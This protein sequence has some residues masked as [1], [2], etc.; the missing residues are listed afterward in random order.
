MRTSSR[1]R[2]EELAVV[3]RRSVRPSPSG[4]SGQYRRIV[5]FGSPS[6]PAQSQSRGRRPGAASLALACPP[7]GGSRRLDDR[8]PVRDA[9][10]PVQRLIANDVAV[11]DSQVSR[12]L[13]RLRRA[14]PPGGARATT[15]S[16][17]NRSRDT[18]SP[19]VS[20]NRS[21]ASGSVASESARCWLVVQIWSSVASDS[22]SRWNRAPRDRGLRAAATNRSRLF[23]AMSGSAQAGRR[24][25]SWPHRDAIRSSVIP[26]VASRNSLPMRRGFTTFS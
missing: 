26:L 10:S 11:R 6:F 19:S 13:N 17:T 20:R 21:K 4:K 18:G 1:A 25:W 9:R 12:R 5:Q 2:T 14:T 22:G 24:L 16:S 8:R 3:A 7:P 15:R 23:S